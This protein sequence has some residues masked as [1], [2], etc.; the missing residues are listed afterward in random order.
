M[1]DLDPLI[2][3]DT[4][5]QSVMNL[6]HRPL[7][8]WERFEWLIP[9]A[10]INASFSFTNLMNSSALETTDSKCFILL[11]EKLRPKVG[12]DFCVLQFALILQSTQCNDQCQNANQILIS[13]GNAAWKAH[14][15]S[16]LT[17]SELSSRCSI[18]PAVW[19]RNVKRE[20]TKEIILKQVLYYHRN[21]KR[22]DLQNTFSTCFPFDANMNCSLR[23]HFV[24]VLGWPQLRK[25][26]ICL[27][28]FHSGSVLR[29]DLSKPNLSLQT[30]NKT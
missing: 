25:L 26:F 8:Y 30:L 29:G 23:K 12:S 16:C 24:V 11:W 1:R 28:V 14:T 4:H 13:F 19:P 20:G 5:S 18:T 27:F 10:F 7:T 22:Y 6:G 17:C 2:L 15:D 3:R 21:Q 9:E